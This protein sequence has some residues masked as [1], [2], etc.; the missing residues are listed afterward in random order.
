MSRLKCSVYFGARQEL[1][2][3]GGAVMWSF[4]E[5]EERFFRDTLASDGFSITGALEL[6]PRRVEIKHEDLWDVTQLA[7]DRWGWS[8][9]TGSNRYG[10]RSGARS[11]EAEARRAV[12]EALKSISEEDLAARMY[13]RPRPRSRRPD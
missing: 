7:S 11:T 3:V 6:R 13:R 10:P 12:L 9:W 5:Q 8:A 1:G 4:D 2:A